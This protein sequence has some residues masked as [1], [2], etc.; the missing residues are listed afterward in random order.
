[1]Q[2]S[3]TLQRIAEAQC[4]YFTTQ[5]AYDSGYTHPLPNYHV[6]V[7]NWLKAGRALFRLP[8][9]ADSRESEFIRCSLLGSRQYGQRKVVVGF[10]SAL[11]W[12]GLSEHDPDEVHLIVPPS[13]RNN[14]VKGCVFHRTPL[15]E[16][17]Y[18]DR[19]GFSVTTPERTL[20]D[21]KPDLV[22]NRK[23]QQTVKKA[24]VNGWIDPKVAE[25]LLVELPEHERVGVPLAA[26]S[27]YMNTMTAL[28]V[29]SV[30]DAEP[31]LAS[32]TLPGIRRNKFAGVRRRGVLGSQSAF[33][34]V[35]LLVVIAII[36]ILASL[37]MPAVR[38]GIDSARKAACMANI[39]QQYIGYASY[40]SEFSDNIPKSPRSSWAGANLSHYDAGVSTYLYYA[41]NYLGIKTTAQGDNNIRVAGLSGMNDVLCCPGIKTHVN[42]QY[43]EYSVFTSVDTLKFMKLSKVAVSNPYPRMLVSDRLY[44]QEGTTQPAFAQNLV[45]HNSEGGNVLRGDGAI[46]WEGLAAWPWW[47]S[48]SGEGLTLPAYKYYVLWK[49]ASWNGNYQWSA[50][51]DGNSHDSSN[52]PGMFY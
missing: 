16:D 8:E 33:T 27:S 44:Y 50:P 15:G 14:S 13:R 29:A 35:E 30:R 20:L 12:Y 21:M 37:L 47:S 45:G 4:G 22:L 32:A 36:G 49:A 34:L 48:F 19:Q 28:P 46:K 52:P 7:G 1:M 43:V 51:P 10:D 11:A 31:N 6:K 9:Y 24:L 26:R 3:R 41:N 2:T 25:R 5:Q 18:R 23:W 42:A 39:K 17:D 40:A 38:K